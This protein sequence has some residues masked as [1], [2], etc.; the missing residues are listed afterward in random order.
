VQQFGHFV[1]LGVFERPKQNFTG[2]SWRFV[3]VHVL[4]T[5]V[6]LRNVAGDRTARLGCLRGGVQDIKNHMY[7][8][9]QRALLNARMKKKKKR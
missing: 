6:V 4:K 1:L 7:V 8:F 2:Y 3:V 9:V 5:L